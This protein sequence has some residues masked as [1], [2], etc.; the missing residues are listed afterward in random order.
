MHNFGERDAFKYLTDISQSSKFWGVALCC[1]DE[2]IAFDFEIE[3]ADKIETN[4]P[5][6]LLKYSEIL[7]AEKKSTKFSNL[8]NESSV[9][10]GE[11][12]TDVVCDHIKNIYECK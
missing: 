3:H 1:T 8:R 5:F 12:R 10:F 7:E 11:I 2:I 9:A 6:F 4:W